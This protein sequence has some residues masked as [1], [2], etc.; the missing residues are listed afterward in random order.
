LANDFLIRFA[1][2]QL[3]P[4][5]RSLRREGRQIP[6]G[7]KTFDL[8]FFLVTRPHQVVTKEE[9]LAAVW[10]N[11]F[12]EESNLSQHV[13]LLR[14]AI[15]N[16]GRGEQIIVTVPGKGYQF[17]AAVE[18]TPRQLVTQG[19]GGLLLHAVQSVTRLVVEEES[20]D[21]VPALRK[22]TE[23]LK[24]RRWL[25]SL[26][27]GA[28]VLVIGAASFLGWRY[29][30][31]IHGEHIDL[32]LSEL[33]N[34][35]GDAD[36]DR[37][38]NQALT[39][40]LEQSPFLNLLSRSRI[41]ETLT[42]MQRPLDAT[43]TPALARE[44]CERSNAQAMLH[45]TIAKLGSRYVLILD[46]DSCVSGKQIAGYKA[47]A[48][49]KEEVLTALDQAAGR[50]R[51]QLG[52]SSASLEKFQ[53]PIAQATTPSLDAL[54]AYTQ[55]MER[56]EHGDMKG[57]QG[58]LEQAIVLDPNFASAYKALSTTYY[59]RGDFAQATTLV[60]K[61]FDLRDRATERERL[62]IEIAY[63]AYGNFDYEATIRSM[64]L[65]N[66]IY[67]N[68][69]SNWGNLSNMYTQIGQ[70]S[71]AIAAGEQG[72]RIDPHTGIGSTIL[73]RAY[74][75]ANRFADAQ[76]VA[77]A[78]IADG[79]DHWG[80]HSI[81]FQIAF[82]EHDAAHIKSEGEW[83]LTH[84]SADQSLDDLAFAAATGG[85]L[86]ESLDDFSRSRSEALRDGDA[87]YAN[88]LL[89]DEAGVEINLG[90]PAKA[91]ETL[92]QL[93]GNTGGF[94][95]SLATQADT[96]FLM[97]E[98]GDLAPAQHF[99][100]TAGTGGE[101]DT[102][103]IHCE[104]PLLRALLALKAHKPADAVQLLEPARPYQL[105]DF[106]VPY[107]RA[108]AEAEAGMLDAAAADYRLILNNQGVDPIAPVYS[109]SHLRL[110]RVLAH[111]KKADEA[112]S[113]YRAFF[114]AWSNADQETG[115]LAD[116]E[117]EYAQL[118]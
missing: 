114:D 116:A 5:A 16:S 84:Q 52:E 92:K 67:P 25:V 40:D 21:G 6:L 43:L 3:D 45:G 32:V 44:I 93:K 100:S 10:P 46:A 105:R 101:K 1:G 96:A 91:A 111:L 31:P 8:L 79:K 108:L 12:V 61:A 112:R 50:L 78:S 24:R 34:T 9:L 70:Y 63:Y 117:R 62:Q 18:Q 15:G 51:S 60:Q 29:L 71:D 59:N 30:H 54:R 36:F 81:L 118:H 103:L 97:A 17:A 102:V 94:G 19:Q 28:A 41:R 77:N 35:T 49:S 98:I 27:S 80:T 66:Q 73:A 7:P 38:L 23:A 83:G 74:K 87:D 99:V 88:A 47:E 89:L 104:L 65:F 85:K 69:A 58:L 53:T 22:A 86:R 33:E 72:Y 115:I 13:F 64:K 110:A 2:Y 82:A 113:E 57:S 109:L 42:Q 75:R 106:T 48:D 90:E 37:V 39:I 55:S 14:K 76:R 56:F 20:D 4:A 26:A 95:T 68:N 11:S 107:L